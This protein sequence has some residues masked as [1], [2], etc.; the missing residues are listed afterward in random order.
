MTTHSNTDTTPATIDTRVMATLHTFFRREFRLA[1]GLVRG[2]AAGD[3]SRAGVVAGHLDFLGRSL[4]HH[5]TIEDE[6]LWPR[7]LER[8]PQELAPIVRL[9]ESQH[10]KVDALLG[11][12][13]DL[14]PRWRAT[15]STADGQRLADLLDELH[16][17]LVEHLDAEEERLVPLAARCLTQAEWDEMGEVGRKR[18]RRNEMSL[19]LG[20]FAHE[21]DPEVIADMLAK[22]PAPI[23]VVVR[24]SAARAFRKH[25]LAV[26]GTATP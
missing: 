3:H 16:T 12:I 20:M 2:V 8:V 7:L 17:H 13:G 26:H 22:A 14:L 23:R 10:E 25:A 4:H 5:H 15:A 6:L 11:E 19:V 24:R 18:T 9:M 1:G 21:G